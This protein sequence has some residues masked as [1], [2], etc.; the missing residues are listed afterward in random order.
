MFVHVCVHVGVHVCV[1]GG[2][3]IL[4]ADSSQPAHIVSCRELRSVSKHVARHITTH[5]HT[6]THTHT[7]PP[8]LGPEAV[9]LIIAYDDEV[10]AEAAAVA[11]RNS[12][13]STLSSCYMCLIVVLDGLRIS[14]LL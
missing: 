6:H 13:K 9:C 2:V 14:L 11:G 3:Q 8:L 12:E 10:L 4:N 7:T 5:T 1:R